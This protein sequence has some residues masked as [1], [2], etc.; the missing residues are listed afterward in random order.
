MTNQA[1]IDELERIAKEHGGELKPEDVVEAARAKSS[2]LHDHF[3]WDDSEAA[4]R[5]RLYEARQLIRV[6]LTYVGDDRTPMRV[7]VSLTPDRKA[8]GGGYRP[9]ASVLVNAKQRAQLLADALA[10]MERFQA[11]YATLKELSEVFNSHGQSSAKSRRERRGC[12]A[13]EFYWRGIAGGD[14]LGQAWNVK[15]RPV[16]G[17][18]GMA[19]TVL[20]WG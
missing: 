1:V 16:N 11:K 10:E 15:T 13:T 5:Y 17:E 14:R 6:T 2:P 20:G 4:Q 12:V 8:E 3:T 18:A 19:S 7:F 9:T